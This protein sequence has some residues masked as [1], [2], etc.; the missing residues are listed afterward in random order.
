MN[1][2]RLAGSDLV[3]AV[4]GLIGLVL[5]MW[6][7]PRQ[8][9]DVALRRML[10]AEAARRRALTFLEHRG[11]QVD[12]SA[13]VVVLRRTT[14]LLDAWQEHWGRRELVRRL[15]A[16]PWLP[17]Y[18]WIV[19]RPDEANGMRWQVVLA[20]DGTIWAF[21]GPN[22][23]GEDP[24][25]RA[26]V[27]L[28]TDGFDPQEP[29]GALPGASDTLATA[30]FGRAGPATAVALARYHLQQTIGSVLSL[31][32]DSVGL[33]A[34]PGR[35]QQ[36]VVHFRGR[37]LTGDSVTVQVVAAATG[38]L[39]LLEVQ[40]ASVP[41]REV[42]PFSEG[43]PRHRDGKFSV[44]EI[45]GG[46]AALCYVLLGLWLLLVF[47]QRLQRRLID[48]QGPLRDAVLG[49]LAFT[50]ATLAAALP[51]IMIQIANPW[52]RGMIFLVSMLVVGVF[53]VVA[54]F[55]AG[56]ASDA[57]ARDR[58]PEKLTVLALLR[59]GQVRN[60]V[61]GAALLRGLALG[62]LLLGATATLLWFWP[63]VGLRLEANAWMFPWPGIQALVWMGSSIWLGM[64]LTY[65]LLAVGARL[66]RQGPSWVVGM[67]ALLL[68]L[69]G[70][71]AVD[72][73]EVGIEL[74]VHALW[75][76][77]LGWACWRYEPVSSGVGAV[78]AWLLWY[79]VPGWPMPGGPLGVDTWIVL[80]M[81]G[82]V[83]ALGGVGL[84]S[85]RSANELPRYIPAY[86]QELARQERLERELEIARQAQASLLPQALP[87]VPGIAMAALCQPAYE[88]GGDYYDVFA[89]PDGRLAIVVGDVSG[90]G[91]QAAFFMTLIKGHVRALSMLVQEPVE[92]LCYL[93]QLFRAQAPRG[94]FV[95]MVYGLLDPARRTL[96]LARAGHPPVLYY[97]A[98][99]RRVQE[100]RPSGM[101]IGLA[102]AE[103]FAAS[104]AA[105]TLHLET[106]DR[107]LFYTDGL[108]ERI[109]STARRWGIEQLRQWLRDHS[110]EERSPEA[111][112]A[113]LQD[114]LQGLTR[115]S[116]PTDDLTAILLE[117]K[118]AEA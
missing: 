101:G 114:L 36:V 91:I 69:I 104:L 117:V 24:A 38:Q 64:L 82:A 51:G 16:M 108:T 45:Q 18:R 83:G 23:A 5:G 89:L 75:G 20:G 74:V 116:A 94:V 63:R 70:V 80:G 103:P 12:T 110:L 2:R 55:V 26:A 4:S 90:K 86:L 60:V 106:G 21:Q 93:N 13:V 100:L 113:S 111:A 52:L 84:R 8:H 22:A 46:L 85:R 58:W 29:W 102:D 25:A 50:I 48:T 40:W 98:C 42:D 7:L 96:T 27:G 87:E 62:G 6:L 32:P 77:V 67:L 15:K 79:S 88:V 109:V 31:E 97:R 39:R 66:S 73:S 78:T 92:L 53:G 17:A 76:M 11:Y 118:D 65:V 19:Y 49:G 72:L 1:R 14:A 34:A 56:S 61:V 115:T 81:L 35:S 43:P 33:Q 9:P 107:V 30:S 57:L 95:T 10:S 37:A 54:V 99:E 3:L 47:L 105:C 28:G 71:S 112:L 41:L 68:V 44:H 59:G